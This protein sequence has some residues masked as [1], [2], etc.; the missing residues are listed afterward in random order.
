M[1]P[2]YAL[3]IELS[4]CVVAR[5]HRYTILHPLTTAADSVILACSYGRTTVIL[6]PLRHII[7]QSPHLAFFWVVDH[8]TN[9]RMTD[10]ERFQLLE[11]DLSQ[12]EKAA[13][14]ADMKDTQVIDL[15]AL[16]ELSHGTSAIEN[17][18]WLMPVF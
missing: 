3:W 11:A 15:K 6:E 16:Q 2:L 9:F 4:T 5:K 13:I 8:L 14:A 7:T 18:R 1:T 10:G 17:S 12:E